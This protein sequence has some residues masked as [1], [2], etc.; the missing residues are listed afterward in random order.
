MAHEGAARPGG[1]G[2]ASGGA[3]LGIPSP[4]RDQPHDDIVQNRV[5]SGHGRVK[6]VVEAERGREER[7][8][9]VA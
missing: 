2:D 4:L 3:M 5:Y 1:K 9:G 7:N 8:R 6:R